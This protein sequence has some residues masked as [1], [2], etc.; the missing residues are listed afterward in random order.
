LTD[1]AD[2]SEGQSGPLWFL[3]G[4]FAVVETSPGVILG[5]ANRTCAV[6]VGKAL[7]FPIVNAECSTVE[8]NGTTEQELRECAETLGNLIIPE[9]LEATIDGVPLKGLRRYRVQSPLFRFG[10]LPANNLLEF[11]GVPAPA[12]T[13][14]PAVSDGVHL[15]LHPLSPGRHTI[16]YYGELDLSD[17]GN[18]GDKFIQDITY[19]LMVKR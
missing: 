16:R 19:H 17:F 6:P 11:L 9:S 2:C 5:Q 4:T 14:S 13:T 12:G 8:G 15:L 18:P 3:G 7:F 10:P 1:T